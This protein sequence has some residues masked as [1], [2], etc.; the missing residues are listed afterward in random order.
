MAFCF[1][2]MFQQIEILPFSPL[3]HRTLNNQIR[4]LELLTRINQTVLFFYWFQ[5]IKTVISKGII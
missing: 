3:D 1:T 2:K 5:I 4:N